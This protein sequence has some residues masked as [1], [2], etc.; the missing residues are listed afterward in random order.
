MLPLCKMLIVRRLASV[1]ISLRTL[2]DFIVA[3][4]LS[5]TLTEDPNMVTKQ[6][7]AHIAISTFNLT[8]GRISMAKQDPNCR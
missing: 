4:A 5:R 1:H 6:G 8:E 7:H 3:T 2:D